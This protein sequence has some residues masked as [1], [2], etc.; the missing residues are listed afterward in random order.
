MIQLILGIILTIVL[1]YFINEYVKSKK[2]DHLKKSLH[3]LD[4]KEIEL[5]Y[6]SEILDKQAKLNERENQIKQ[7]EMK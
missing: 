3:T 1:A 2:H 6:K 5:D 4:D 7:R